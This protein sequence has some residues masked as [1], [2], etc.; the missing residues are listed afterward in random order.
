MQSILA[1][2]HEHVPEGVRPEDYAKT[3]LLLYYNILL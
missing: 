3:H 2:I 1:P